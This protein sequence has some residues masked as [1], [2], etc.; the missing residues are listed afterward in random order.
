M[1]SGSICYSRLSLI[2]KGFAYRY[3]RLLEGDTM[4]RC[5]I[6]MLAMFILFSMMLPAAT[7]SGFVTRAGSGEPMQYVNVRVA[8]T[9][10]GMQSNKKGYFVINL[11][12][13]GSYT[14]ELSLISYQP[15]K[16]QFTINDVDANVH[17]ELSMIAEAIELATIRVS[18]STEEELREIRP[19]LIRRS[20]EDVKSVVSPIEADVFR[21]VLALPGVTPISDFS[22]GLYVRGGSPDQNLILLD[23][24]D[25]Y[26]PNHFGGV[27]STF[28]SDAV[29]NIELIKGAY[30]A[31]YGGRLSSV[32]DVTN[33]QGNRDH[34]QGTARWSLISSSATLEGPWSIGNQSGS[35]MGSFR[36][37]YLELVKALLSDLPDYYFYDG[38]F[39]LNWDAGRRDKISTSAYFG[40]DKL[41]FDFGNVLKLDWGNRTFTSQWVH[42]FNPRLFS[43]FILAGSD[44]TSNFTQ[45]STEGEKLYVRDNGIQDVSSKAMLT[46]KP[47]NQHQADFGWELK[48][49]KTWLKSS[50]SYQYE[51]SSMPDVKV[52]SLTSSAYVQDTWDPDALWTLQPGLR[53]SWY[54][55][56]KVNLEQIPDASYVNLDPRFSIR[57]KLN[58][59]ESVYASFGIYHQYLTLMSADISTPFDVWFPLDGSLKPGRSEHYLLGYKN[60]FSRDFALDLEFYYKSYHNI[61]EYNSA[62]DFTWNNEEGEL[63]DVFHE[64][65]GFT[66]GTD[67]LLRTYWRGLEGFLGFT[68]SKTKRKLQDT[69]ID[70]YTH[71]AQSFY[72]K[73]DRSYAVS[74]VQTFN[75]S[76]FTGRQ[77]LGA[78]FKL[79][80][81]FA[82]TSGQPTERPE[83]IYFDGEDFQVIY[84]YKD[85][86]RL[87]AYCRLDLST[88]YEWQTAW[89]SI[90]PYFEVINVLNRKNV[91]SRNYSI[92]PNDDG[93]LALQ[94]D[95]SGQFPILPFIGVNVK[96]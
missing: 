30:P 40:R 81:N 24:I 87:P 49:N 69:N 73:Y 48:Y 64:G 91:G 60:Q 43:Q 1:Q 39:K 95:D 42:L 7:V 17:L 59:A 20:T 96:W 28:N 89:G 94:T 21:A 82:L 86:D 4:Y 74:V 55:T 51:D 8:E 67:I 13:A 33:R 41:S 29:E 57:R 25:V 85:R 18:G 61:L 10:A 83:R 72:P 78:D 31:K 50:T 88:K 80:A 79:G 14:L 19:S 52:S 6:V 71:E 38:H 76:Q 75:L 66:Y 23:D 32:L 11:A 70:P 46:Y 53:V 15:L 22:S 36:R 27:F 2:N 47:N 54:Q 63:A 68:L 44:F 62:T 3:K 35:Y 9:Q 5:S 90:E 12:R 45:I 84:S 26:N 77:L 65:K 34:H 16:Q 56:L 37:T 92:A 93:E 58:L